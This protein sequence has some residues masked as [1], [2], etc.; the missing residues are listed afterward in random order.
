MNDKFDEMMECVI[1]KLTSLRDGA[2]V[3]DSEDGVL[4]VLERA[5]HSGTPREMAKVVMLAVKY[6]WAAC[7]K[8]YHAK[9][10]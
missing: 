2:H 6:G 5:F 7:E 9:E 10:K 8:W 1:D 3:E 4:E